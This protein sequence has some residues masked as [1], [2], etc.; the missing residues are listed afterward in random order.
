MN[1][2]D[3][4]IDE[5]AQKR[6]QSSL[7]KNKKQASLNIELHHLNNQL[8]RNALNNNTGRNLSEQNESEHEFK[9]YNI[10]F[11]SNAKQDEQIPEK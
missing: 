4:S 11:D 2:P 3:E 7:I 1:D 9:D 5:N 6:E 8:S 10:K